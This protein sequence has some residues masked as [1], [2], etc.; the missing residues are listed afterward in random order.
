MVSPDMKLEH[1]IKRS[2]K[3]LAGIK[4][5]TQTDLVCYRIGNSLR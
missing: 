3:L 5:Q 1:T 2:G 4:G